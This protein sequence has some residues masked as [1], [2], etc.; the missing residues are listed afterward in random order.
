MN[1]QWREVERLLRER[2]AALQE[3]TGRDNEP[4]PRLMHELSVHQVEIEAQNAELRQNRAD[5]EIARNR[6][7]DL[8]Q[9]APWA[10]TRW[11]KADVW[12]RSTGRERRN[13]ASTRNG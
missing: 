4:L 10:T 7:A 8:F 9:S 1:A 13:S 6:Y 12:W 2:L 11:T 5:L 3:A